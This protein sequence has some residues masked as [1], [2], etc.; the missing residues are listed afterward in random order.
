MAL[1]PEE[2]AYWEYQD[3]LQ[4]RRDKASQDFGYG[5]AIGRIHLSQRLLKQEMTPHRELLRLSPIELT[6]M[7]NQL[8]AQLLQSMNGAS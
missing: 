3:R 6:R 4:A 7:A 2:K 5:E 8:E 1:S